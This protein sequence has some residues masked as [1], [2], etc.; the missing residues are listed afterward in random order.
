ML[1]RIEDIKEKGLALEYSGPVGSFSALVDL[2][3]DGGCRFTEPIRFSGRALSLGGLIE[4]EGEVSTAVELLCGRCLETFNL[5]LSSSFA[6]TFSRG[7]P[8]VGS[9][10][11]EDEVEL[12]A[13][14]MGLIP[15]DGDELDLREPVQDQ[16]L[17]ALPLQALCRDDCRGLCPQCGVDLNQ[18]NCG[19]EPP[20]FNSRFAALKNLKI[21]KD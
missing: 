1:V 5:S 9:D 6:M 3:Q 13:E 15:F 21:V 2:Q 14:E 20:A 8:V 11:G 18:T 10:D 19:C 7:L 12:S 16:I 4:I 17:M